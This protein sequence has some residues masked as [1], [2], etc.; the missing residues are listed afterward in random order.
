MCISSTVRFTLAAMLGFAALAPAAAQDYAAGPIKIEAPWLRATPTGAKV[1]GGYMKL[2][3]TG[4]ETD[5]LVG[6]SSAVAGGFEVHEMRM[7]GSVMTMRE[8]AN[9]LEIPPGQSVELKPGSYHVMLMDLKR[10]VKEGD[11]IKGTLQFEK[12]GKIEVE[13]AV[14]GMGSKGDAGH[15]GH[16]SPG[17]HGRAKH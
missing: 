13:Y 10:P 3:N 1:A 5:R 14:R 16:G 9:G 7:D 6:G 11:R 12:A 8:V 17:G 2:Y 15:S 4:K